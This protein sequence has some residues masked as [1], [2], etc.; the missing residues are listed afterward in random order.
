[1]LFSNIIPRLAQLE[2]EK[3]ER[4]YLREDR[5]VA[6]KVVAEWCM[7]RFQS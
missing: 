2:G 7:A 6:K 5:T 3:L 4:T 1:L